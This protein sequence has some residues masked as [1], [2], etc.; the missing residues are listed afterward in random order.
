M[1]EE[2]SSP[3]TLLREAKQWIEEFEKM[4]KKLGRQRQIPEIYDLTSS[5]EE[6][7]EKSEEESEEDLD[8]GLKNT[9]MR[10]AEEFA[11]WVMDLSFNGNDAF[12]NAQNPGFRI[13]RGRGDDQKQMGSAQI[14]PYYDTK[15]WHRV[16]Q[17]DKECKEETFHNFTIKD[18]EHNIFVK[19]YKLGT[20]EHPLPNLLAYKKLLGNTI[21]KEDHKFL[22][23]RIYTKLL[24]KL[25][26]HSL[27]RNS[28]II[29]HN[30]IVGF[31]HFKL[32]VR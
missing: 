9:E 1:E 31:L 16:K 19:K 15:E 3:Q 14:E 22:M 29:N 27:T 12:A 8:E 4:K 30:M 2:T 10:T 7:E 26:K 25:D 6:S 24:D 11:E 17:R 5:R 32:T 13:F 21:N 20:A 28:R 23:E 18:C